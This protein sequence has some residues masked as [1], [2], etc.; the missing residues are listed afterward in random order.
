MTPMNCCRPQSLPVRCTK[1]L[2]VLAACASLSLVTTAFQKK[3]SGSTPPPNPEIS[4]SD[5]GLKVMNADG[6]NVRTLVTVGRDERT[7]GS[8]WSPNGT[9]LAFGKTNLNETGLW[10]INLDGTSAIKIVALAHKSGIGQG[11][12]YP[13]W[14]RFPAPDGKFKIAFTHYD[15]ASSGYRELY[16][17]NP[18][19]TGLV[20]L[21][22]TPTTS[23]AYCAWGNNGSTLYVRRDHDIV[24]FFLG[25]DGSGNVVVTSETVLFSDPD[26]PFELSHA[27]NSPTLCYGASRP[28]TS[29]YQRIFKVDLISP[30]PSPT[31]IT[32]GEVGLD[33]GSPSFSPDDSKVAFWRRGSDGGIFTVNADG[34]GMIRIRGNSTKGYYPKWKRA[35]PGGP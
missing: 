35:A 17:V 2:F 18:D 26:Y 13:D 30:S 5:V 9:A 27:N 6:T 33:E 34:T 10:T 12:V 28:G 21:T 7:S 11:N 25:L 29:V 19:G 3:G 31:R 14:S 32:L 8:S 16:I 20:R 22:N 1:V 4:F 23:E 24:E 15:S